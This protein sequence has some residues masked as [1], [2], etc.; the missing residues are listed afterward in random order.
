MMFASLR[1]RNS[2][3]GGKRPAWMSKELMDEL[4]ERKEGPS[5]VKMSVKQTC[6]LGKN[7]GIL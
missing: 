7:I 3:K 2:G 5:N 4:D 1:V 6:P